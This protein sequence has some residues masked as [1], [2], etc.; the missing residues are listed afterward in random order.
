MA[1]ADGIELTLHHADSGKTFQHIC[2][3]VVA[4]TGYR[5][6]PLPFM[7]RWKIA[8]DGTPPGAG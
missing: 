1:R 8:Y 4:A 2:D 7:K 6:R 5:N 3:A